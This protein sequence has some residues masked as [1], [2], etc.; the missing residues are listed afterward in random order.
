MLKRAA[1]VACVLALLG[2]GTASAL[3]IGFGNIAMNIGG[4]FAPKA[5]PKDRDVPIKIQGYA[6]IRTK[7]G[8]HPPVLKDF[9]VLYDKHGHVETRGL[10]HCTVAKL[11]NTD[12][13]TARRHCP[14]A[15][16]GKGS[17]KAEILFP[18][19]RPV[20]AT[21]PITIFNGPRY[22]GDPTVVAH[23]YLTIPV[24]T[25]FT[26]PVRIE[27]VRKGRYG[28]R[29]VAKIPEIAGGYGSPTFGKIKVNRRWRFKG[30]KLSFVNARCR[31]GRLQAKGFFRFDNG[32]RLQG[33]LFNRCKVRRR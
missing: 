20:M 14:K 6:H 10:P 12:V 28:Y 30:K 24:P 8:S 7:D 15:I 3:K 19:S 4:G 23:A 17:G 1:A 31:G 27:N 9:T 13:K 25:T 16:V 2:A 26:V 33:T 21:S 18:D 32:D 5:L 29:T 22:R 11:E